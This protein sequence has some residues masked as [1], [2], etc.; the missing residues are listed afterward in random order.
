MLFL[1]E[2]SYF[3]TVRTK[4]KLYF[5]CERICTIVHSVKLERGSDKLLFAIHSIVIIV[6]VSDELKWCQTLYPLLIEQTLIYDK[7]GGMYINWYMYT[8]DNYV[9]N[10]NY[11]LVYNNFEYS[12]VFIKW[13]NYVKTK[14]YIENYCMPV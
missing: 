6:A 5:K 12:W 3:H 14:T 10:R 8:Y 2:H 4:I 13:K 7:L 11:F 9:E 1:L